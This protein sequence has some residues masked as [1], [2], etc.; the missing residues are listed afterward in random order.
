MI[1]AIEVFV[2]VNM[3]KQHDGLAQVAKKYKVDI[4]KL[5][6]G[7][8]CVFISRDKCRMKV[9]SW[10]GVLSYIR[11]LNRSRP[12]SM[13]AL[14]EFPRA[15]NVDGTFDYNKALKLNLE[16]VFEAKGLLNEK[17]L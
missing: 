6:E 2:G 3:S 9:I 13:D 11:T 16:K 4:T 7:A 14:R 17:R 8:A 12:F 10:N 15:F 5:P 1:R